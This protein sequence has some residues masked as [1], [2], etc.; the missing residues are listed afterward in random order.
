MFRSPGE[1]LGQGTII[2]RKDLLGLSTAGYWKEPCEVGY[3]L[4]DRI[5]KALGDQAQLRRPANL[6]D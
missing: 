1:S 4:I 5:N 3:H 6:A 2:E